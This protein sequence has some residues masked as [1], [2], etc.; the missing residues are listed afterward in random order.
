MDVTIDH[1]KVAADLTDYPVYLDLSLMPA[2]FWANVIDGGDIRITKADLSTEIAREIVSCDTVGQT[3]EVHLIAAGTLS[4]SVDTVFVVHFGKTGETDYAASDTYGA[5]N[6]WDSNYKMVLHMGDDPDTSHV[7]DSTANANAGTKYAAAEP[8]EA[9]GKVGQAQSFDGSDDLVSFGDSGM[10]IV[11]DISVEAWIRTPAS[12]PVDTNYPMCISRSVGGTSGWLL[13][14]YR[15]DNPAERKMSFIALITGSSWGND[16]AKDTSAVTTSTWYHV[17]GVR[18]GTDMKIYVNGSLKAT[19]PGAAGNIDYGTGTIYNY[20]GFK[21]GSV[22]TYHFTGLMDETRISAAARDVN[23]I[24]TQYRNQSSPAT[25]TAADNYRSPILIGLQIV[26]MQVGEL[27]ERQ[28]VINTVGGTPVQFNHSILSGLGLSD[29][30]SLLTGMGQSSLLSVLA[31]MGQASLQ[32]LLMWGLQ[33]LASY[34]SGLG[35]MALMAHHS[36]LGVN[37]RQL[38]IN[39]I[40]AQL[41]SIQGVKNILSGA[42]IQSLFS[43]SLTVAL[44]DYAQSCQ[45]VLL[46]LSAP[47]TSIH[48]ISRAVYLDGRT[49]TGKCSQMTIRRGQDSI[50]NDLTITSNDADLYHRAD[51]LSGSGTSRFEVQVSGDV[52]YFLLETRSGD[53]AGFTL[54]GRDIT[55]RESEEYA[56]VIEYSFASDPLTA[57]TTAGYLATVSAV[58]WDCADWLLPAD[59]DYSGAPIDGIS[60]LAAEIGG[61]CR[62]Q[63]DGSIKVRDRYPVRPVDLPTADY[64]VAYDQTDLIAL[65]KTNIMQTIYDAVSVVSERG[66]EAFVPAM[67]LEEDSPAIGDLVHIRVFWENNRNSTDSRYATSGIISSAG[68]TISTITDEIVEFINSQAAAQY[69]V[70]R[71]TRIQWIGASADGIAYA[72]GTRDLR[73]GDDGEQLFRAAKITYTTQYERL[74]LRGSSVTQLL[75]ALYLDAMDAAGYV[76]NV[77]ASDTDTDPRYGD[78][79]N[80]TLLTSPAM[81]RI[82]GQAWLD[83]HHYHY[84]DVIF[85]A[86][87]NAL[88]TDGKKAYIN[89]DRIGP[90]GNYLIKDSDIVI[91]GPKV[92]NQITARRWVL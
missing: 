91:T 78:V 9:T 2:D 57:G 48:T 46:S 20:I 12:W 10:A 47:A 50:F 69:P 27:V 79:I 1:T 64:D 72:A 73:I 88:A 3:G 52:F 90:R 66:L 56:G 82:A 83:D 28:S 44:K 25:F 31:G 23:W 87:Y 85:E 42:P 17:V 81:A 67:E 58:V 74:T 29:N 84:E 19:D 16:F 24:L 76:V 37:L 62:A 32:S 26:G 59:Y 22:S 75:A 40:S 34:P 41:Q 7:A 35:F 55:A 77:V 49:I 54:W 53:P 61:I 38:L 80:T 5:H 4:S 11:G 65:Q 18:S 13:Y 14:I 63:A 43:T 51:P 6:V 92:T 60:A 8:A 89:D 70:Q 21:T 39:Q 68:T 36:G 15:A 45:H 30:L 71:I 86:P 33:S